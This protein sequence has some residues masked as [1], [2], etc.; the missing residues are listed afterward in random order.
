M[1]MVVV[2][3]DP[4]DK[5]N[6]ANDSKVQSDIA[7]IATAMEAYAVANSG[8]YAATQAIL[9]TSG[10]LKIAL[11]A[12]TG[13]T[14]TIT[15]PGGTSGTASTQLKSK[16]YLNATPATPLWVWCSSDGKG[17]ARIAGFTCP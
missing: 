7:K 10:D 13:Y 4:I 16:K 2:G 6:A 11:T 15:A 12:P 5:I 14:Y 1:S 3:I 8:T 9:I 17:S